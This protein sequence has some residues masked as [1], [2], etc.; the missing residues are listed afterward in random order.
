MFR[1]IGRW[2]K[3]LGY[4]ITGQIDSARRA[5]D[6]D[7]NVI[8]AKYDDIIRDKTGQIQQYKQAVAGLIA[9]QEKKMARVKTLT[10][11]VNKLER[12]KAGAL[13]KAK[14]HVTKLT[15]AGKSKAEI[16]LDEDYRKCLGAYNDFNSTLSE[17]QD[18]ITELE[19][20]IEEYQKRIADHKVQ[21]QQLLRDLDKLKTE[22][23]DAVA[24][25]ITAKHEKELAD[26]VSGI[27]QDGSA[28]ELQQLR[29][30][31]QEIK[32]EARISK[33]VA[34]TDSKAQ[35]AEF[36]EYARTSSANDEFD[37]LVGLAEEKDNLPP[38]PSEQASSDTAGPE[39][40][41]ALPE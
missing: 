5:L 1:A 24:D 35:E 23:S 22:K 30:L 13:A 4:L 20:D 17:K 9:Q 19:G 28:E 26:M 10:E 15:E 31:R 21:M 38:T 33:E 14:Q 8:R 3:A 18:H 32:A 41:S 34:G 39:K 36:L 25:V 29:D 16:Q 40:T 7:P 12:L 37:A 6:T 11:E 2:F 27:S